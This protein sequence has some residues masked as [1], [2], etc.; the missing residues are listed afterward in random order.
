MHPL[1]DIGKKCD[2]STE[3][4]QRMIT[5]EV[6]AYMLHCNVLPKHLSFDEFTYA[7]GQMAFEYINVETGDI[8]NIIEKKMHEQLKITLLPNS[9]KGFRKR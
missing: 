1:T 6:K 7:K 4:I 2:L 5:E 8:I 9:F 3:I